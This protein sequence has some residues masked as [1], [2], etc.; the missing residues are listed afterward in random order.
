M[1]PLWLYSFK[2]WYNNWDGV[3]LLLMDSDKGASLNNISFNIYLYIYIYTYIICRDS[4]WNSLNVIKSVHLLTFCFQVCSNPNKS[5]V[6][7]MCFI[8]KDVRKFLIA[9]DWTQL[10][11][12]E[13]NF[14]T[15]FLSD[16]FLRKIKQILILNA[17]G[18]TK[19]NFPKYFVISCL[20]V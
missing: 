14:K 11:L 15:I 5:I 19:N 8:W 16:L 9:T 4:I 1:Q 3:T 7:L 6:L 12:N 13:W 10:L 2:G 18:L 17:G 20:I